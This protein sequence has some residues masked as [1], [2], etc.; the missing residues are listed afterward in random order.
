MKLTLALALALVPT[1]AAARELP[2]QPPGVLALPKT[3]GK[4]AAVIVVHEWWGLNDFAKKKA[5]K[6]ADAGYVAFAVDLYRGKVGSDA[7]TAHQLMRALPQDRKM[8]DMRAAFAWLAGLPDVDPARIAVV[9]WCM[10]GGIA[11]ELALAEPKLRAAVVYYGGLPNDPKPI[12]A[13]LLGNFGAEDKGIPPSAVDS[14]VAAAKKADI[15]VDFKVYPGAGHAFASSADP[16][17]FKADAARDADA[18]TDAFLAK[19]L[20]T[21]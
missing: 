9:G 20:G 21:Q 3:P 1:I 7:D 10:G 16:K 17:T 14:F 6:F 11:L 5:Q 8:A 12:K 15:R 4:H 19:E 2:P 13:A 18:R